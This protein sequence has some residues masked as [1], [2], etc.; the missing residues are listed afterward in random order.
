MSDPLIDTPM[1]TSAKKRRKVEREFDPGRWAHAF[2]AVTTLVACWLCVNVVQDGWAM[3]WSIW[4]QYIPRPSAQLPRV[5]GIVI[6]LAISLVV[7][8][9]RKNFEYVTET[10]TEVSQ[11]VWPTRAETRSAVGVVVVLTIISS[12]ILFAF[13]SIWQ[14]ATNW[15]YG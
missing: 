5:I 7:W 1:A 11:V 14:Y 10:A 4:P 3:L 15:I 2:F 12:A 13:D 8:R 9:R 6:G